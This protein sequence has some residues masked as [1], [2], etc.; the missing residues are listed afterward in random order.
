MT[1]KEK[2]KQIEAALDKARH[3]L[4]KAH[5]Y[6]EVGS[7]LKDDAIYYAEVEILTAELYLG[8][9]YG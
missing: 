1:T 5:F 6:E 4:D 7:Q 8:E 3:E 9:N 2:N